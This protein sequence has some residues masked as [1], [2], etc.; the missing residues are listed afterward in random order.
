MLAL[1]T[2]N[3]TGAVL[4]AAVYAAAGCLPAARRLPARLL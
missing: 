4:F 2:A 3:L 1:G